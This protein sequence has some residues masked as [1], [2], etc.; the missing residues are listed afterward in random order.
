MGLES[1]PPGYRGKLLIATPFYSMQGWSPYISSL[2]ASIRVLERAGVE[3][4]FINHSGD[5]YIDRARNSI[6]NDF[7][8]SEFDDLLFIDSDMGWD[9]VGFARILCAKAD[10]VG[11]GYPCKN[12]WD[13]YGCILHTDGSVAHKPI[14]NDQGLLRAH[15]IPMG[16][17]RINKRVFSLLSVVQRDN[18]YMDRG[19]KYFD[20]FGRMPPMGED[21]SFCRRWTDTGGEIWVEPRVSMVHCGYK[22]Y[23]GN[24]DKFLQGYRPTEE[25]LR[26]QPDMAPRYTSDPAGGTN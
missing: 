24:Y 17:T 19:R 2:V 1:S 7:M 10:F 20:F 6:A 16:L 26:G 8:V 22:P 23:Q 5:S 4:S 13:F 14:V 11:A 9:E 21:V 25:D 15:A 3:W 18:Y 12:R